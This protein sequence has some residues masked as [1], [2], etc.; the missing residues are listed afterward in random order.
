MARIVGQ[1]V[2]ALA[3]GC[4]V[5]LYAG[6]ARAETQIAVIIANDAPRV[7]LDDTTLRDIYLKR[8]YLDQ[9][10]HP[11]V[12]VNLPPGNP[13]RSAFSAATFHMK[14]QQLQDYWNR[15][16]FQGISPPYVLGSEEAVI[17]F[18]A[19]TPGAIGYIDT[20]HLDGRVHPLLLLPV[21]QTER[22]AVAAQCPR[23][24][25]PGS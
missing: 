19:E 18:V 21:P 7:S 17:Q 13:L 24:T 16:Y 2:A 25:D 14:G 23:D 10:G 5:G 9:A 22:R 11:F 8:I 4:S 3:F 1:L 6:I 12:P 15:R 20:C